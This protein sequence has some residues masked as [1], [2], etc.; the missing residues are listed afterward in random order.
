MTRVLMA[1]STAVVITLICWSIL[2]NTYAYDAF[3]SEEAKVS[4]EVTEAQSA[5]LIAS[6][7]KSDILAFAVFAAGL[8]GVCGALA[9]GNSNVT[10]MLAGGVTG[11]ILGGMAGTLGAVLGHY[12]DTN[13]SFGAN[14][15][16]Y[17]FLRWLMILGPIGLACG[18]SA[19]LGV[20]R[21]GADGPVGGIIGVCVAVSAYC[22]LSGMV[23]D[24]ESHQ[25]VF[26]G[27]SSNRLLV[28]LLSTIS[29]A[30]LLSVQLG[31]K[32]QPNAPSNQSAAIVSDDAKT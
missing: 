14:A 22:L 19:Q 28:M 18:V 21:L 11:V 5:E 8:A 4:L 13:F 24:L 29:L 12:H 31:T 17:W 2:D 32:K 23:T 6:R 1:V 3:A 7:K 27:A 30:G 9:H 25:N 10:H 26:P 15:L 16:T 20:R